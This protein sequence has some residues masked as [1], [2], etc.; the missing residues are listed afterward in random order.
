MMWIQIVGV[1][2]MEHTHLLSSRLKEA[3]QQMQID[4]FVEEIYNLDVMLGN[5]ITGLPAVLINGKKVLEKTVPTIEELKLLLKLQ[6]ISQN[7]NFMEKKIII[8]V[9]FSETSINAATY[10]VKFAEKLQL[11]CEIVHTLMPVVDIQDPGMATWDHW[12]DAQEIKLKKLIE[13]LKL[14]AK[15]KIFHSVHIGFP[16]DI[17]VDFSSKGSTQLIIMGSTGEKNVMRQVFGS[18]SRHVMN[19]AHCPVIFVPPKAKF[20]S[21]KKIQFASNYIDEDVMVLKSVVELAN[22]FHAELTF[23]HVGARKNGESETSKIKLDSIFQG[24]PYHI[25]FDLIKLYGPDVADSLA[26]YSKDQHM[27]LLIL[28]REYYSVMSNIFRSSTS[29][30]LQFELDIP[31]LVMH[32]NAKQELV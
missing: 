30:K 24:T 16:S 20:H 6:Q 22:K 11:P 5:Q 8:P 17:I 19:H 31:M 25:S 32:Y 28:S 29:K 14:I 21:L 12:K 9:D 7:K 27:D 18:V 1:Q 23:T 15:V 2:G 10:A 4:V 13:S 3:S 26:K